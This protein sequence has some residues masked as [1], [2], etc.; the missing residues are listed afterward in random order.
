MS[1]PLIREV[2][3]YVVLVPGEIEKILSHNE[4]L[5]WLRYLL[6]SDKS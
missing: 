5:I 1:D 4:T 6:F 2:D 3:N